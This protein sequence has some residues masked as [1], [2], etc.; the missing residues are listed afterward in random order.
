MLCVKAVEILE[1]YSNFEVLR[2]DKEK[3]KSMLWLLYFLFQTQM[4]SL[5][6]KQKAKWQTFKI[7][8][9]HLR[10]D[11]I[12]HIIKSRRLGH[13]DQ[14]IAMVEL[15]LKRRLVT[16]DYIMH[17]ALIFAYEDGSLETIRTI[18]GTLSDYRAT[19]LRGTK[20]SDWVWISYDSGEWD[21]NIFRRTIY[22]NAILPK[23]WE[24]DEW[25]WWLQALNDGIQ[26]RKQREKQKHIEL[27]SYS[28]DRHSKTGKLLKENK[29]E[30][31]ERYSGN[32]YGNSYMEAEY[33]KY[34]NLNPDRID[35]ELEDIVANLHYQNF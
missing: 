13:A 24:T 31:D 8:D 4:D 12:S 25:V 10:S 29:I 6:E 26:I 35:T 21:G 20:T 32:G 23:R 3:S 2:I 17:R 28:L 15:L 33:Q 1:K 7:E 14:A 19:K 30:L 16:K 18:M 22:L 11:G 5:F 27:P 34:E 9:A